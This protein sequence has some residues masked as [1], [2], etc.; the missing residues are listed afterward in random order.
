MEG[1]GFDN[2]GMAPSAPKKPRQR[3]RRA[4]PPLYLGGWIRRLGFKQ[5]DVAKGVPMNEG[6]L[7]ELIK[8]TSK[9]Y[10]SPAMLA[11][12]ARFLGIPAHYLHRPPPDSR[13]MEQISGIDPTIIERLRPN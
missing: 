7:S 1:P 8:G 12:I 13:A 10:P 5:R 11:D 9:K 3:V 6:Y 2:Q 4:P